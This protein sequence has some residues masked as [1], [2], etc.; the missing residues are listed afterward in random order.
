MSPAK[1][2]DPKTCDELKQ[3]LVGRLHE[4]EKV[5]RSHEVETSR[6]QLAHLVEPEITD[7][8]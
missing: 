6:C 2:L 1:V 4:L 7:G 5:L 3:K 8:T